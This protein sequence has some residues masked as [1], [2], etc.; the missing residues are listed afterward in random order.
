MG[1]IPFTVA[2][3]KKVLYHAAACISSNYA[4][5]LIAVARNLLIHCGIGKEQATS[6]LLPL[7]RAAFTNIEELG[8][9][10]GLTG[11]IVRGDTG[12]VIKHLQQLKNEAPEILNLYRS[13]GIET[14]TIGEQSQRLSS[15]KATSMKN[16]LEK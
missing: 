5:T 7:M 3:D 9:E 12:T 8:V 2:A 15:Q 13:L 4:V 10:Q 1:G 6:L 14:A 11:P 16:I